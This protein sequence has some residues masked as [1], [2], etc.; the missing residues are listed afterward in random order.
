MGIDGIGHENP[1]RSPATG[2]SPPMSNPRLPT[3]KL[4]QIIQFE[5]S[6]LS[7][8]EGARALSLSHGAISKYRCAVRDAG[9]TWDDAQRLDDA[10]L[11]RRIWKAR[12]E[13]K[14][15]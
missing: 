4:R 8:R 12:A 3:P 2:I 14:P 13:R 9:V 1:R 10:E 15:R 5:P 11:E 6:E 7:A